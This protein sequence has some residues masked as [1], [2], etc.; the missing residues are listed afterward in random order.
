MSVLTAET[1]DLLQDTGMDTF[2]LM[3][4]SFSNFS[5]TD[6]GWPLLLIGFLPLVVVYCSLAAR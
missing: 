6:G 2:I 4:I 3:M 1:C 5:L